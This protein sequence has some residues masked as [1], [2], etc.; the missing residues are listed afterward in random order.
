MAKKNSKFHVFSCFKENHHPGATRDPNDSF[1]GSVSY[2]EISDKIIKSDALRNE[3]RRGGE[4][5]SEVKLRASETLRVNFC[6]DT[7]LKD[8]IYKVFPVTRQD[9]VKVQ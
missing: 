1:H 8:L 6:F 2:T 5:R 9:S 4:G 3:R 7:Y